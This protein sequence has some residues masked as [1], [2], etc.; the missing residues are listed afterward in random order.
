ME[1]IWVIIFI[2]MIFTVLAQRSMFYNAHIVVGV[3]MIVEILNG[4]ELLVGKNENYGPNL[5]TS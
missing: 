3:K 2:W 4:L 1:K 5:P